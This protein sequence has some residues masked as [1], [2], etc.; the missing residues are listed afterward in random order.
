MFGIDFVWDDCAVTVGG[1]KN[2]L[3]NFILLST[4]GFKDLHYSSFRNEKLTC[5]Q[6]LNF[7][8]ETPR[9]L[10]GAVRVLQREMLLLLGVVKILRSDYK[11]SI[12]C[13]F[14][15]KSFEKYHDT[16]L[17]CS[18]IN[19]RS[20]TYKFSFSVWGN[21]HGSLFIRDHWAT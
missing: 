10:L 14:P 20:L 17:G 9:E 16:I 3:S 13:S 4:V 18:T 15:V 21:V 6:T 1:N 19:I 5:F 11:P 12:D 2:N 7:D 8:R